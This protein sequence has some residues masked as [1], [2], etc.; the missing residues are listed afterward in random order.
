MGE[1]WLMGRE[2]WGKRLVAMGVE[3]V[4]NRSSGHLQLSEGQ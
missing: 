4:V 3:W 2:T 1:S